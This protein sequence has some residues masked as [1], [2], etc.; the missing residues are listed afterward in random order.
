MSAGRS[1]ARPWHGSKPMV[2]HALDKERAC[3][4]PTARAT[5]HFQVAPEELA[6]LPDIIKL[7]EMRLAIE[8]EMAALAATRRRT[9]ADVNAMHKALRDMAKVSH[10]P[11]AAANA[12]AAFHLAIGRGTKNDYYIR[13]IEF[14]G[15]RLVPSRS[16]ALRDMPE[17]AHDL[18][19]AKERSEHDAILDAIAAKDPD[20]ARGAARHH[21]AESLRRHSEL[22]QARRGRRSHRP[23]VAA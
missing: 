20:T 2:W 13:F 15:A 6:G 8:A 1:S 11:H 18:Y 17:S 5:G 21:M 3:S 7:L 16:L 23:L 14:L 19:T 10:D 4:P 22:R 9:A 12:D